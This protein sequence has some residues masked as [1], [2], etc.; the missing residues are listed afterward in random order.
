MYEGTLSMMKRAPERCSAPKT[1]KGMAKHKLVTAMILSRQAARAISVVAAHSATRKSRTPALHI[2]T[3]GRGVPKSAARIVACM[4]MPGVSPRAL[5][6]EC[7]FRVQKRSEVYSEPNG[8]FLDLRR[9]RAPITSAVRRAFP[10][11]VV[12][13][14][15]LAPSQAPQ[16]ARREDEGEDPSHAERV[17]RP[18]EQEGWAGLG[19]LAAKNASRAHPVDDG[20]ARR[21][22]ATRR[23]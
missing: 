10:C 21:Q 18:D 20:H 5:R 12:G 2:E 9:G 6:P 15:G 19:D 4:W 3:A 13:L 1:A 7:P 11:G 16:S 22:E 23:A 17:K 8:I 14:P